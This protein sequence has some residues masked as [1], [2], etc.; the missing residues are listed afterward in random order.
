MNER[1]ISPYEKFML[2]TSRKPSHRTRSFTRDLVRVIPWCFHF[3]RGSCSLKDLAEELT[4]L[5]IN[6]VLIL[7]ERKG[8]PSLIKFYKL[9]NEKLEEREYRVRI[10][11]ISL[12]RE[13]RN[14]R[15][16]FTSESKFS[17]INQSKSDFGEQLYTML[18]IF[19]DFQRT[20]ALPQDPNFKGIAILYIYNL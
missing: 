20:R 2:T 17:V 3:T 19:F 13:L 9:V 7:H 14:V 11:G 15:S 5:G 16:I 12:G 6:R 18:S 1:E 4:D 10:K 8:N